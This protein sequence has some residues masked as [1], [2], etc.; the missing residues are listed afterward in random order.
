[1]PESVVEEKVF[2]SEIRRI[3]ADLSGTKKSQEKFE[4]EVFRR[5]DKVDAQFDKVDAQFGRV[6]AQFDRVDAR[7]DK[8]EA[9]I[10]RVD[11]RLW[12]IFGA[13]ILSILVPILLKYVN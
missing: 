1:M 11:D 6:Y 7:I 13:V 9:R 12:W 2:N 8:L 10:D 5:F 3:D 4:A